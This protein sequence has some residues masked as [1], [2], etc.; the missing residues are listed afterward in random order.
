MNTHSPRSLPLRRAATVFAIVCAL[1]LGLAPLPALRAADEP[2]HKPA[3]L[4]LSPDFEKAA[5]PDSGPYVL[6]L[7]NTSSATVTVSGK[8]LL[9]VAYHAE[10]KARIL[11]AHAI[12][13]G[14]TWSIKGLA[15]TDKVILSSP[16]FLSL[17]LVVP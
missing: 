5:D 3:S 1:T 10:S 16:G 8:V 9:S 15:A 11:P 13:A 2:A 14:K 4:P 17:E 7:T 12:E 6:T